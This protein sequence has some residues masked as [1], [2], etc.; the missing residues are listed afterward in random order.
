M[1]LKNI[2]SQEVIENSYERIVS[3]FGKSTK[4]IYIIVLIFIALMF[5]SLFFITID[6]GVTAIGTIKP[7]GEHI[8]ITAPNNGKIIHFKYQENDKIYKGDTLL[9]VWTDNIIS[10]LPALQQRQTE[11]ENMLADLKYLVNNQ[12]PECFQS[13]QYLQDYN[14]YIAQLEDITIKRD[15]EKKRYNREKYL[16]DKE[17]STPADFETYESI[18]KQSENALLTLKRKQLTKWRNEQINYQTELNNILTQITQINIQNQESVVISPINGNIHQVA[19]VNKNSYVHV[20]QQLLEL[21]PDGDLFVECFVSSK[22]IG[23]ITP[24]MSVRFRVDAFDYTQWGILTGNVVD[25]ANDIT[26]SDTISYYKIRCSLDRPFLELRN[27][28]RG[29]VKKGMTVNARMIV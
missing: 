13:S 27:G 4:S 16:F 20:G 15:L 28:F 29:Y 26:I 2:F 11:L 7:I 25:I 21:S 6:I 19:N 1:S 17:I 23:L 10:A 18:Y 22:D 14:Y 5:I 24:N 9:I 3:D 12:I 8:I